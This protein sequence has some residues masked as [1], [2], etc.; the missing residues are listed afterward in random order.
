MAAHPIANPLGAILS[1]AMALR[2]SFGHPEAA[3]LL[4]TA[5]AAA[6]AGG[7]R[8]ADIMHEGGRR[9]STIE[10]GGAVLASLAKLAL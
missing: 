9:V 5:V 1:F 6:L 4:E 7:V 8:T 3:K 2:L 10:M